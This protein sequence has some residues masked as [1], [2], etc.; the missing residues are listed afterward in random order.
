MKAVHLWVASALLASLVSNAAA[1]EP[2]FFLKV[3]PRGTWMHVDP[4]D[5]AYPPT[6]AKL[7]RFN[8]KAGDFLAFRPVGDF[9][10]G[11]EFSDDTGGMLAIFRRGGT[12]LTPGPAYPPGEYESPP[13]CPTGEPADVSG[14][15][16][17]FDP[18][19]WVVAQVPEGADNVAFTTDDCY[20]DDNTDPDKDFGV[21]IVTF[22]AVMQESVKLKSTPNSVSARFR[23]NYGMRLSKA[24]HLGGYDHFNWLQAVIEVVAKTGGITGRMTNP[25]CSYDP[26]SRQLCF[27]LSDRNG[28]APF[29]NVASRLVFFIDPIY[30][31]Y[32]YMVEDFG[33]PFPVR[34][35]RPWQLDEVFGPEGERDSETE[36]S[37]RTTE[38]DLSLGF[39]VEDVPNVSWTSLLSLAGV[40]TQRSGDLLLMTVG[41]VTWT[42]PRPSGKRIFFHPL[43]SVPQKIADRLSR[44]GVSVRNIPIPAAA[45]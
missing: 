23:P 18:D 13:T 41:T 19:D 37:T 29:P 20:R 32:R 34:D 30:G 25:R 31:G 24:A 11:E 21:E 39:D 43:T 15:F 28:V 14:D 33:R 40:K 6:S 2:P 38:Y 4:E 7:S 12:L 26:V 1:V 3:S 45:R 27:G 35:S 36:L 16:A 22:P 5:Q 44:L 10:A 9:R 17:L 42:Y 8:V